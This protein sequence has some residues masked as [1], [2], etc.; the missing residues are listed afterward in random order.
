M[1]ITETF[2]KLLFKKNSPEVLEGVE[3][4]P[5]AGNRYSIL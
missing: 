1:D 5:E 4:D 2:F 3:M